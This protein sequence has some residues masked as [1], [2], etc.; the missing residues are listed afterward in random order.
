[1]SSSEDVELEMRPNRMN[2][3][4]SRTTEMELESIPDLNVYQNRKTYAQGM[5]DLALF[6]ANVNQL[7][8]VLENSEHPFHLSGIVLISISLIT[9]VSK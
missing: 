7:R 8:Y 3:Q 5:L 2:Q 9:Q 4:I 1:M 6:S